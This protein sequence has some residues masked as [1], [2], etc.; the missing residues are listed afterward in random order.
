[1]E[2]DAQVPPNA[3][4]WLS[5][6]EDERVSAIVDHHDADQYLRL[7]SLPFGDGNHSEDGSPPLVPGARE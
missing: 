2:Y 5:C 3:E 4:E 6:D 1:M 7:L